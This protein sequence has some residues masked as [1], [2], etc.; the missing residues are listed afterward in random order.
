MVAHAKRRIVARREVL[1]APL[2]RLVDYHH[3]P[4]AV[5]EELPDPYESIKAVARAWV[6]MWNESEDGR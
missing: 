4:E 1:N 6:E 5:T 3:A 2:P